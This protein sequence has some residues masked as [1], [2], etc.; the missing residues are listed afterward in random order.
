MKVYEFGTE[1]SKTFVMFQC[2]AEPWWVF[3]SSAEAMSRDYHVYLFI[4]DGHDEQGTE[5]ISVEKYAGDAA[6]YLKREKI[7][8]IEGMY[9]ISM[10][11]AAV[12]RFLA[13]ENIPVKKAIID[14]GITPYPYPKF[15]C[16]M[17][18]VKDWIVMMI[19]TKSY[20]AMK[21]AMPPDRWTPE[22][23]DPEEHY[24]KIYE[25][26]KHHF[27]SRTIYN[28]FWSANNYEMPDPVPA[29][30]A[31]ITYWYGEEEAE[32]RKNNLAYTLAA[33]P[34]TV[35]HEFR[36]MAHGELVMMFPERFYSEATKFL[37]EQEND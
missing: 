25:F 17:I 22:G 18:A 31:K 32:A 11:G 35:P 12:I 7:S 37:E 29:V 2:A 13:A 23:E 15:L 33:Y 24:R 36:G 3:R 9:G 10:G 16:R 8:E 27:S 14:A 34:Q 30:K 21:I 20:T 4:A 28:V 5:F 19:G 6:G 1:N 26:E